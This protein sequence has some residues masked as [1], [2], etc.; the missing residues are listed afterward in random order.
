MGKSTRFVNTVSS[1]RAGRCHPSL[2][3][4]YAPLVRPAGIAPDPH[5]TDTW[6][7][8]AW[9]VTTWLTR[10]QSANRKCRWPRE[11]VGK[12]G[13]AI[14]YADDRRRLNQFFRAEKNGHRSSSCRMRRDGT[15]NRTLHLG[16][17]SQEL[18]WVKLHRGA[19]PVT[20]CRIA[21]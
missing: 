17:V 19:H 18:G 16:G 8:T 12:A 20:F 3:V 2:S 1:R 7:R 10:A 21:S 9:Q 11:K 6:R 4:R 15:R 13:K 14:S 5:G